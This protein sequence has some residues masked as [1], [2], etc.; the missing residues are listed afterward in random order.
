MRF[1]LRIWAT[2]LIVAKRIGSQ[3]GLAAA[4]LVGLVTSIAL[5]IS[6]PLYSEAVFNRTLRED[7]AQKDTS[8]QMVNRPPFAFLFNYS[9]GVNGNVSWEVAQPLDSL[10]ASSAAPSLGLPVKSVVR[11]VRTDP[12]GLFAADKTVYSDQA[13]LGWVSLGFYS[14]LADHI[15]LLQGNF[16]APS[17]RGSQDP[18]EVLIS[19]TLVDKLGAQ[20][21][22]Q[23]MAMVPGKTSTGSSKFY[24][25]PVRVSGIWEA[26]DAREDFW[27]IPPSQMST[28]LFMPQESFINRVS[29]VVPNEIFSGFWY[30]V[31]DGGG[32]R[33][34]NVDL[35]LR[36]IQNLESQAKN[37]LPNTSM[38]VS[39][40]AALYQY[41]QSVNQ[42]TILL[43]AFSIPILGLIL[44]FIVLVAGLSVDRQRNEIAV[45]RSRGGTSWQIMGI[46]AVESAL[47]ALVGLA[48]GLP[49]AMLV[50]HLIGQTRSFMSFFSDSTLQ[51]NLTT[52]ALWS[53]L[54][55]VAIT[56]VAE[57]IP[58]F[59][60][61]RHTI[62]SYKQER[63]RLMRL[64]WWQRVY[65]DVLL[66]IPAG[67]GAYLLRQQGS[68]VAQVAGAAGDPFRNPLLFLVPAL[69]ILALALLFLRLIPPFLAGVAWV[70]G[71]T[72]S[73][74]LTMAARHLSRTPGSYNTPLVIL[75]LTLSLSAYTGSLAQTL[76]Q[77]LYD[78]TY[79]QV[80]ADMIFTEVGQRTFGGS[81]TSSSPGSG[82]WFF[83]PVSD[84]LK[85]SGVQAATR[86][87]NYDAGIEA[88][89]QGMDPG[90]F[91]GVDRLDFPKVA[92][93]RRDF[94]NNNLGEL[95]NDLAAQDNGVLLTQEYM[96][97]HG[98][99]VGDLVQVLVNT[100]ETNTRLD[101]KVVGG[102]DMFP[103]WYPNQGALFVGNLDYLFEAAGQEFPYQVWLKTNPAVD[104]T[105]IGEKNLKVINVTAI[106][107]DSSQLRIAKEQQRPERQGVFGMLFIGF[108]A[109]AV[110]TVLG[111]LLY[112]LFSFRRRFIELGVLRASG[113]SISQMTSY[114][115]CELAFLLLLGGGAGT[116]LGAWMSY[117][118]IPYLQIGTDASSRI[119][120]FQVIIAWPAIFQIYALFTAL[121]VITL[122]VLVLL[123]W[124]MKIFQAIKLGETV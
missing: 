46:T 96:N 19:S 70:A 44:A 90:R 124:R 98:I 66:L 12:A 83:F 41:R 45:L 123:L 27:F 74:G 111:F 51:V 100:F 24:Q 48:V 3:P 92:F 82:E 17:P 36:R 34:D 52:A 40:V 94:S 37:L 32:V 91:I 58:A 14:N 16:P 20:V 21:G 67:Y 59:G 78:Q 88:G 42:L 84:Y 120:P 7:I 117:L 118:F 86:V 105:L 75:I 121:F 106:G 97:A 9:G 29:P 33:S 93:W 79:Y 43:Y 13:N 61:S 1:F 62:V 5:V 53:G 30:L 11:Y 15:D 26:T 8:G 99:H 22:E 119:P 115:V 110:L 63:A 49:V 68:L 56:L 47:L 28:L 112:V 89:P 60:A 81:A 65:V 18:V 55:A 114:M 64:P 116:G 108:A 71:R 113:L 31:V 103:T 87:G 122:A 76:D 23:F 10:M 50:A 54:A 104:P 69:S 38:D 102:L 39:P 2:T 85:V 95:M 107:W 57:V 109:A 6:I 80:G 35:L 73:V 77:H 72:G 101:M 25:I 4:S